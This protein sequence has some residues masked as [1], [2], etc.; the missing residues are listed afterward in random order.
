MSPQENFSAETKYQG[1][2]QKN[3]FTELAKATIM[4]K[5]YSFPNI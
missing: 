3:F 5:L 2:S 1:L 4:K